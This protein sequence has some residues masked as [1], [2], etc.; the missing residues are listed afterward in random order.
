MKFIDTKE[1]EFLYKI[2]L[3]IYFGGK[4]IQNI[5]F[6]YRNTNLNCNYV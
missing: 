1:K 5:D 6:K 2:I 3:M 4:I